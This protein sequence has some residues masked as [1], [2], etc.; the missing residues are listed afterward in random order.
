MMYVMAEMASRV[1]DILNKDKVLTIAV[2]L[3]VVSAFVVRPD[4]LYPGY[5]DFRT[6]MMLFSLMV[7][8][9]GM[10]K[11]GFF[12]SMAKGMI[13]RAGSMRQLVMILIML[14]FFSSMVITNDVA[15]ITFVPLTVTVLRMLG[16]ETKLKWMIPVVVMQTVAA[17][18]GSM[19]TPI[20]NPQNLYLSGQSGEGFV[21][22]MLMMAPLTAV[23]FVMIASWS[24]IKC[25]NAGTSINVSFIDGS[26]EK[27]ICGEAPDGESAAACGRRSVWKYLILFGI[28]VLAVARVIDYRTAFIVTL[29]VVVMTDRAVLK[30]VDYSLLA[31]FAALFIF[32]G[33][34]GRVETFSSFIG[35][36]VES[37]ELMAAVAASQVISNVPAALLLSGFT[38]HYTTL[39]L[40]TNIGGLGTMIASMASLISYKYVAK[41]ERENEGQKGLCVRYMIYFT[42]V[43]AGFL[44]A[45]IAFVTIFGRTMMP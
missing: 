20:G 22:F 19:L 14:C 10:K 5:M 23:S 15:L 7:V 36:I 33:N 26:K 41:E 30:H 29:M 21:S 3:A 17:N 8:M 18:L 35:G 2:I 45:M 37:N 40:G 32:I 11:T 42:A 24:M 44:A 39:I 25:R 34:L 16:R 4:S 31:T 43:N 1:K 27:E 28:C 13:S 12:D 6:L 9:E 38:N